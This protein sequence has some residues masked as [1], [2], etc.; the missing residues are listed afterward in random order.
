MI[1]VRRLLRDDRGSSMLLGSVFLMLLTIPL[2]LLTIDL[3]AQTSAFIWAHR[4]TA[5]ATQRIA[6]MCQDTTAWRSQ[7]R[8]LRLNQNCVN[9]ELSEAA[10]VATDH[11]AIRGARYATT[12]VETLTAGERG[13]KAASGGAG[14]ITHCLSV[15]LV[16]TV[17]FASPFAALGIGGGTH[18]FNPETR[19]IARL[20]A[21]AAQ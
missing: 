13:C 15:E 1:N 16:G 3:P 5:A 20:V 14:H 12:N 6:W 4:T 17:E 10:L 19:S 9:T 2:L 8:I 18:S 7:K 11:H 21:G